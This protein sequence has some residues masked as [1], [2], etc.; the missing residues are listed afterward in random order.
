MKLLTL[1]VLLQVSASAA[2]PKNEL[3]FAEV[4]TD[5]IALVKSL[6]I[7]QVLQYLLNFQVL[8]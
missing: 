6:L 5:K 1:F 4:S 2:A 8:F 7:L 3:E